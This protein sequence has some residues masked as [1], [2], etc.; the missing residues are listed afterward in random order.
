MTAREPSPSELIEI[1]DG[2]SAVEAG[3]RALV[4]T[5]GDLRARTVRAL[6]RRGYTQ[7]Q[8][9]ILLQVSPQ[10]VAQILTKTDGEEF[11]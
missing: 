8:L 5:A 2:A 7:R 11:S 4:K 10:R 1:F 6:R 9:G 3:A